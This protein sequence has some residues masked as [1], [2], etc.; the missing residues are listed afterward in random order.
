MQCKC[1]KIAKALYIADIIILVVVL[2]NK[3]NEFSV[4]D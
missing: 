3:V 4:G 1:L 2:D